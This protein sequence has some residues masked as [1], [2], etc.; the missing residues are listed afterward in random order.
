MVV[1]A[2]VAAACGG[3]AATVDGGRD[4]AARAALEGV[5][6]FLAELGR[7]TVTWEVEI[8]VNF[9]GPEGPQPGEGFN[10][11]EARVGPRAAFAIDLLHRNAWA[12]PS[13]GEYHH[14]DG[15]GF[16]RQQ[17]G[18]CGVYLHRPAPDLDLTD[19]GGTVPGDRLV[20]LSS[21]GLVFTTGHVEFGGR[22][23]ID[24]GAEDACPA[25]LAAGE[26]LGA[27]LDDRDGGCSFRLHLDAEGA[28]DGWTTDFV[29][30]LED[31]IY[32][33]GPDLTV[34]YLPAHDAGWP[35]G[36]VAGSLGL[37]PRFD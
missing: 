20:D 32:Q 2:A 24:G 28:V 22:V 31:V 34:R 30:S 23:V 16:V 11:Y 26:R 18:C 10:G 35:T 17:G 8:G 27:D 25:L 9:E 6:A 37:E 13:R 36:V 29:A 4:Q 19:P 21:V 15:G 14:P 12:S 3:G 5:D 33:E 7:P 1:L